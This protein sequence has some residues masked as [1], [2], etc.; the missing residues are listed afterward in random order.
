MLLISTINI[1]CLHQGIEPSR[2]DDVIIVIVCCDV[3]LLCCEGVE[4]RDERVCTD[5]ARASTWN[6][7]ST[8]QRQLSS[9]WVFR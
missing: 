4:D 1:S 9:Q 3:V 5:S 7:V 6:R 2:Y 8:I